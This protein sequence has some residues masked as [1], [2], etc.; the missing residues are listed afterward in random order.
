MRNPVRRLTRLMSVCLLFV[1][2][3]VAR[4]AAAETVSVF[5]LGHDDVSLLGIDASGTALIQTFNGCGGTNGFSCFEEFSAGVLTYASPDAP[6]GFVAE[7]GSPCA[8]PSGVT[9]LGR[10]VCDGGH[11]VIGASVDNVHGVWALTPG[12]GS[13]EDI[14]PDATADV[15]FVN[16]SGDFLVDDGL[17]D[18]I[19]EV[20]V[21]SQTPEPSSLLLLL[22]GALLMGVFV[23]G[24][25]QTARIE[26]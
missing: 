12:S 20:Q 10:S 26:F 3:V 15:L 14:L 17:M 4:K 7:D 2:L 5:N 18:Y 1:S 24:K 25:M 23:R 8:A 19:Y 22:T 21:V 16:S 9:Q 6:S 13:L 11:Q